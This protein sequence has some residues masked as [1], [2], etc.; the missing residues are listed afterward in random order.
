SLVIGNNAGGPSADV[1]RLLASNQIADSETVTV[2][3]SGLFDLNGFS[4]VIGPLNLVSGAAN[5]AQVTTGAG[6]LTLGGD[7]T[8]T[9]FGLG[10]ATA[11]V[12][13]NL[14][15]GTATRS[16]T[17]AGGG[18]APDLDIHAA[19]SGAAGAGLTEDG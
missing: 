9:L 17:V 1:V 8:H 14:S 13:G 12:S 3:S 15:L 11:I 6:T 5:A 7:V 18:G 16:F 10:G 2:T 4:D 19:I